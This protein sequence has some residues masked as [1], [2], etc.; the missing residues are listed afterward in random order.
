MGTRYLLPGLVEFGFRGA[1][2]ALV[3]V[4]QR[5][6]DAHAGKTLRSR[7]SARSFRERLQIRLLTG[8]QLKIGHDFAPGVFHP[9]FGN[10]DLLL[11]CFTVGPCCTIESTMLIR[12]DLGRR[13]ERRVQGCDLGRRVAGERSERLE[14]FEEH[15]LRNGVVDGRLFR[16]DFGLQ[17]VG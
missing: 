14:P 13:V 16:L 15:A 11:A 8:A 3:A 1:H 9:R 4:P 17:N 10:R 5:Q 7:L 12:I 6:L 2:V